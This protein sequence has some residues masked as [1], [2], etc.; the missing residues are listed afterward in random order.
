MGWVLIY[1]ARNPDSTV[2]RMSDTLDI[3]ERQVARVIR[4]M[5]ESGVVGVQRDGQRNIYSINKDGPFRHPVFAHLSLG[6]V[7]D[8]LA[9]GLTFPEPE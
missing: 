7:I 2:R 1:L 8:I 3:T 6:E 9:A 5:V 4:D